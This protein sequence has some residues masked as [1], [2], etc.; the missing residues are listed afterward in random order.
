M[1]GLDGNEPESS[2]AIMLGRDWAVYIGWRM[3]T[4][5][6]GLVSVTNLLPIPLREELCR[7]GSAILFERDDSRSKRD[8]AGLR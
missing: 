4:R 7:Y 2:G 5:D 3:V 6:G 1:S 8:Q